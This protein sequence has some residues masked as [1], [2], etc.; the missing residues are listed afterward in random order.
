MSTFLKHFLHIC[1]IMISFLSFAPL[2]RGDS[3]PS[4]LG[5]SFNSQLTGMIDSEIQISDNLVGGLT[6]V[7]YIYAMVFRVSLVNCVQHIYIIQP[8]VLI[9]IYF[10]QACEPDGKI[11]ARNFLAPLY[12]SL[13]RRASTRMRIEGLFLLH[14]KS[15][16]RK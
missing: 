13:F 1:S 15:V 16:E 11:I 9:C 8:S 2:Q 14:C 10:G 4:L 3:L 5:H 7:N 6:T 12:F